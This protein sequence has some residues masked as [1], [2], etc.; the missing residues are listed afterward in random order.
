MLTMRIDSSCNTTSRFKMYIL[1]KSCK[2]YKN[3]HQA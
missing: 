2:R 3:K 1:I